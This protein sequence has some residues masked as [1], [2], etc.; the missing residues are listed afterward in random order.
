M[1]DNEIIEAVKDRLISASFPL[2][3]HPFLEVALSGKADA[4]ITGNKRHFKVNPAEGLKILSP[5][6]FL[7]LLKQKPDLRELRGKIG[8]KRDYDYKKLRKGD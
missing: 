3:G 6:E 7:K 8:F 5:D 1:T 2:S 4:L